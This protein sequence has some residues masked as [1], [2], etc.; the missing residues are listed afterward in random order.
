MEQGKERGKHFDGMGGCGV[1]VVATCSIL[2]FLHFLN[3]F[4]EAQRGHGKDRRFCQKID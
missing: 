4:Y 2:C 3:G 1:R